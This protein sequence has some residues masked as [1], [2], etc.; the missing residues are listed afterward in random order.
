LNIKLIFKLTANYIIIP[1]N[2]KMFDP[3][4]LYYITLLFIKFVTIIKWEGWRAYKLCFFQCLIGWHF[5]WITP[6]L[7]SFRFVVNLQS[8]NRVNNQHWFLYKNIYDLF[9]IYKIWLIVICMYDIIIWLM[10]RRLK[11]I[12]CS[13][14][15]ILPPPKTPILSLWIIF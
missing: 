15:M 9:F 12:F 14:P 8:S 3:L 4:N 1:L 10:Y 6:L 5:P 13:T 2:T 7:L 11:E